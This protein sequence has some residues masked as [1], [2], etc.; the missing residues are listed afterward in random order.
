MQRSRKASGRVMTDDKQ[1]QLDRIDAMIL[2]LAARNVDG[3]ADDLEFL[4]SKR[5]IPADLLSGVAAGKLR[6]VSDALRRMIDAPIPF[7]PIATDLSELTE[8]KQ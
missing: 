2:A 3:V 6:A 7:V 4:V 8:K 5:T 1:S